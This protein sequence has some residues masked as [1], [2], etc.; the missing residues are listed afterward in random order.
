MAFVA[1][2]TP[3]GEDGGADL[4]AVRSAV[5]EAADAAKGSGGRLLVVLKST[6]PVGTNRRLSAELAAS[7]PG[8]DVELA[9]NPEFLKEGA[10]VDDFMYPDRVVVGVNS[11]EAAALLRELYEVSCPELDMLVELAS[12]VEGV[13]G[14]RLTGAGFGGCTV[15]LVRAGR[16]DALAE[17]VSSEY[18]ERSGLQPRVWVFE[19]A[20]GARVE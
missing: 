6:C 1:V 5:S 20:P 4:S 18:P 12:S 15:N 3:Q 14:C 17:A 2:G 9:S 19:P 10:A 13:L 7:H 8:V 11:S 16:E